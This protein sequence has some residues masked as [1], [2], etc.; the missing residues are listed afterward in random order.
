MLRG[1]EMGAPQFE[2]NFTAPGALQRRR[3]PDGSIEELE[4]DA[5]GQLTATGDMR[6]EFDARGRLT[7]AVKAD[8]TIVE[9]LYDYRGA[10]LSKRVTGSPQGN[11]EVRYVDDLFEDHAGVTTAYAYL[12]GRLV[13]QR[14]GAGVRHLHTDHRANVILATR[15][16]GQVDA[17][18]W[19]G[20]YGLGQPMDAVGR[21]AAIRQLRP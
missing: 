21:L 13:G 17:R 20:P 6:L 16:N 12:S 5:A 18:A 2:Y 15:P 4:F 10:R 3:R 14:R 8:G 7:R 9:M 1:D 11:Y 19:L